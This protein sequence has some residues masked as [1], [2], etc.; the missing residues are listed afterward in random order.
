[1]VMGHWHQL[2]WGG[3]FIV[4]GSSKGT[5]EYAWVSNFEPEPPAQAMWLT[6]PEHGASI[7]A[8]VYTMDRKAEGW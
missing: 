3:G 8:P 2:K 5:D 4:N 6:T 7:L 1:M